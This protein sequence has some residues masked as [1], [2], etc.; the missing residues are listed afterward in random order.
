MLQASYLLRNVEVQEPAASQITRREDQRRAN[1]G[2]I[3]IGYENLTKPNIEQGLHWTDHPS[4]LPPPPIKITMQGKYFLLKN[5]LFHSIC[6]V[7]VKF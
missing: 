7:L 2:Q 6:K 5:S 3:T 1:T 4:R